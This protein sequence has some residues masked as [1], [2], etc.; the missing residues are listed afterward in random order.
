MFDKEIKSVSLVGVGPGDENLLTLRACECIETAD[1]IVYDNLINPTILNRA[2][3]NAKLIYAGKISGN[4]YLTQDKINETIVE[5]ALLGE[6]VVR[7]KGGDPYIFGRGGEEAEYLLER[8][9]DFEIVPGVSSFYAGLGYAGIPVTFRG[10]AAEFHVFTGHKKQGEELDLNFENIAKLDGS[11]VFLMGISNLSLIVQGL[12]SNGMN[13]DIGAAVIENGTRYNQ[14]V[15][16]GKLSNIEEIAKREN[17][18]SPALIVVG[19]VCEKNLAFFKKE[20]LPLSGK[21]ILLTATKALLEKMSPEFKKL[22]ANICEMSLIATK[23]IEIDKNTFVL[24]L[25]LATHI[26]FTSANG[27]DIFF[28]KIKNYDIDVRSLYN[29]KICVIGSGSSEAL[30]K[31]GVNADFI[32]SKFDSKSFVEEILPKLDKN[33]RVLMLRANLGNDNLPNGLKTAGIEFR[34]ISIY[35]TIIDYRRSFE[36]NKEIKKFDYVV[37][38]SASAAKA[39]YEMIEDKSALLNRV[40]SIGPVTTKALREFEIEELITAKQYDVKGIVDAIKKL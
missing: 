21:N 6:Y 34:D 8:N 25:E 14:R 24:E 32:P 1:V 33:S 30:K 5:Y 7:L 18:I 2:K 16:R 12:L 23:E 10:E 28:E 9:I 38:A 19:N 11:L 26:L 13:K 27:V 17:I 35:D 22:G 20:I 37:V 36:L 3:I 39:L 31:Y 40:V 29:K 15:F 4:H